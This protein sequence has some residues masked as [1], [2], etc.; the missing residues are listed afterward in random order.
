MSTQAL[1]I[2]LESCDPE[3]PSPIARTPAHALKMAVLRV[4]ALRLSFAVHHSLA[5]LH[6]TRAP[7]ATGQL[8]CTTA[9]DMTLDDYTALCD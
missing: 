7:L 3:D 1:R 2:V 6:P 5:R 4:G 9:H 8:D